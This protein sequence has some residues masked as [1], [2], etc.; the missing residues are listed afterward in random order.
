MNNNGI[1][2]L[3]RNES[4]HD[5]PDELPDELTDGSCAR[6][7]N[8]GVIKGKISRYLY[9]HDITGYPVAHW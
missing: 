1:S 2:R 8:F 5:S 3:I 7:T 6:L 9:I 4:F